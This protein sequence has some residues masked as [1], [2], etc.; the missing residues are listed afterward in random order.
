MRSLSR[1]TASRSSGCDDLRPEPRDLGPVA[2]RV[3]EDAFDLG[4]HVQDRATDV[5]PMGDVLLVR[6]R[7]RGLD[8]RPIGGLGLAELGLRS[9]PVDRGREGPA[10][11]AQDVDLDLRPLAF[12]HAV[13]E[14][15][16]PPPG[17]R[18]HDG[19]QQHRTDRVGLEPAAFG[20]REPAHGSPDDLAAG[21]GLDPPFEVLE[22]E[23]VTDLERARDAGREPERSQDG[24]RRL[25][26]SGSR[27]R[28]RAR[29]RRPRPAARGSRR[30]SGPTRAAARKRWAANAS[31]SSIA[32]RRT[33]ASDD[34]FAVSIS[35]NLRPENLRAPRPPG[36]AG[37]PPPVPIIGRATARR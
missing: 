27:A 10:R 5:V 17:A 33:A 24:R 37:S 7:R 31:A 11:G 25:A 1:T 13:V 35:Q 21:Q 9:I 12:V 30:C 8:D 34:A 6:D 26:A 23:L 15:D 28:R 2:R 18:D 19:D 4:A 29:R 3:A 20:G 36:R 22:P 16:V 14:P 32:S